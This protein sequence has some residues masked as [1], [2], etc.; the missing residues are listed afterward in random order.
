MGMVEATGMSGISRS[1]VSRL[2]E[3]I[4]GKAKAFL[5]RPVEGDRPYPW[6]AQDSPARLLVEKLEQEETRAVIDG[7]LRLEDVERIA[8][9]ELGRP[10]PLNVVQHAGTKLLPAEC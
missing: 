10:L 6:I 7:R 3:A 9:Q 5:D 8:R 4:E 1:R 2:C